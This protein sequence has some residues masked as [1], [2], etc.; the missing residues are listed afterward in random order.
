[1][2]NLFYFALLLLCTT[3]CSTVLPFR[4]IGTLTSDNVKV[5][6]R[7][8]EYIHKDFT[9]SYNFWSE[10]GNVSFTITNNSDKDIYLLMDQCHFIANGWAQDYYKNRTYVVSSARS[11]SVASTAGASVNAN[12]QLSGQ[13]SN[14]AQY[15]INSP[16]S[17][18]NYSN[19]AVGYGAS[20]MVAGTLS[21]SA[22]SGHSIETPEP[23]TIC[24]PAHSSKQFSEFNIMSTPHRECGFARDPKEKDGVNWDFANA[25]DSPRVIENRLT[26]NIK[27]ETIPVI[28]TFYISQLTNIAYHNSYIVEY[29]RGCSGKGYAQPYIID[30]ASAP[31]KF[32]TNYKYTKGADNDRIQKK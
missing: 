26:L 4:Q 31:N 9:I 24:I 5:N 8:Y 7:G 12:A 13:L 23:K 2:K 25:I 3:S 17:N 18:V 1:M 32:Y 29:K 10:G 11:S 21:S 22:Q 20:R 16:I 14:F 27:G 6:D 15:M 28:N 19:A 30:K